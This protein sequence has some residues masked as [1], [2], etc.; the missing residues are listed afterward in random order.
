MR[1]LNFWAE[2][3]SIEGEVR[4]MTAD[5]NIFLNGGKSTEGGR[6]AWYNYRDS[7]G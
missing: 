7:T 2:K 3:F 1:D 6:G 5:V 4:N